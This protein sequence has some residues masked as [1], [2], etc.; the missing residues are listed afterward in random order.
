MN[1]PTQCSKKVNGCFCDNVYVKNTVYTDRIEP[2]TAG[3]TVT[4][5]GL[6]TDCIACSNTNVHVGREAGG[7]SI[8]TAAF[9]SLVGSRAGEDIT[10]GGFNT[11]LGYQTGQNLTTG[12][13]NIFVGHR[14]GE[15]FTTGES[16]III[17]TMAG[18]FPVDPSVSG[19]VLIGNGV[20]QTTSTSNELM[21][22]NADISTPLI[23]GDFSADTLTINGETTLGQGGSTPV[24]R[25]NTDTAGTSTE[26]GVT[27]LRININGTIKRMALFDDA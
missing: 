22:D 9:N 25:L 2:K 24:H 8:A 5:N 18:S 14:A 6:D 13:S 27:Y 10:S 16:N 15:R 7:A 21:I 20:G 12:A 11:T 23:H 17:G 26:A 1:L 3:G 19:N 4:I